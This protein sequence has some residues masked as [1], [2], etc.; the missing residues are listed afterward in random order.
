[1]YKLCKK[2]EPDIK[3]ISG[4]NETCIQ[5]GSKCVKNHTE[6]HLESVS[7]K[8]AADCEKKIHRQQKK[9]NSDDKKI[10]W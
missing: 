1:M 5:E 4:N 8:K 7:H 3:S 10:Q 2:W 6:K 9:A